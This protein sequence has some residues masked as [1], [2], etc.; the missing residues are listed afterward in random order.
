MRGKFTVYAIV[1]ILVTTLSSWGKM[2]SGSSSGSSGVRG[3]SWSSNTGS[4]GGSWGN[5]T[6]GG[7]K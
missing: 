1:V 2:L 6:G 7:H 3:S 4:G 5:G